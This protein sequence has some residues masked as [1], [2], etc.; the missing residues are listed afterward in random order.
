[1]PTTEF[2][3]LTWLPMLNRGCCCSLETCCKVQG[4][5]SLIDGLLNVASVLW[6]WTVDKQYQVCLPWMSQTSS[7]GETIGCWKLEATVAFLV[8][9]VFDIIVAVVFLHGISRGRASLLTPY[10]VLSA[11]EVIIVLHIAITVGV[12]VPIVSLLVTLPV[13][14]LAVYCMLCVNSLRAQL[15]FKENNVQPL[16][17]RE[18]DNPM[19]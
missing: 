15:K 10:L 18:F 11:V 13:V 4:Y 7:S 5:F 3:R 12:V 17:S 16:H 2:P 9:S 8:F 1:M 19:V 6:L 14:G